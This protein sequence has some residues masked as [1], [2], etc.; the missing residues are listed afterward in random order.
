MRHLESQDEACDGILGGKVKE[1]DVVINAATKVRAWSGQCRKC[2]PDQ[3]YRGHGLGD[4][5][6]LLRRA[7]SGGTA[8]ACIGHV[9]PEAA[10][11]GPNRLFARRRPPPDRLSEPAHR[12]PGAGK[13]T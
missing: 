2:F 10:E 1:G 13:R 7:L 11:G 8:G 6:T 5:V 3:L 12:Y 9:S 4:K